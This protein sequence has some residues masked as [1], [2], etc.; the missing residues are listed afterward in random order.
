MSKYNAPFSRY[1][2]TKGTCPLALCS[3]N[4]RH[5][6]VRIC[7]WDIRCSQKVNNYFVKMYEW[8]MANFRRLIN[9]NAKYCNKAIDLVNASHDINP[10]FHPDQMSEHSSYR[11]YMQPTIL[12]FFQTNK[13]H[14]LE[15]SLTGFPE[16]FY[17]SLMYIFRIYKNSVQYSIFTGYTDMN[18]R[19]QSV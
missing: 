10:N 6:I 5:T 8:N 3:S 19:G 13:S 15:S 11:T 12:R 9:L 16:L 2:R 18:L 4:R 1:H 17:D 14:L 7:F